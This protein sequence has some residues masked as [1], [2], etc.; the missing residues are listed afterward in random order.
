MSKHFSIKT[1]LVING[2]K[3]C[4]LGSVGAA[5]AIDG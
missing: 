4:L 2:N 5:S 3:L 1:E